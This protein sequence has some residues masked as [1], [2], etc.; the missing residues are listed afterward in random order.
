MIAVALIAAHTLV[1]DLSVDQFTLV[2]AALAVLPWLVHWLLEAAGTT[3]DQRL[4]SVRE[5]VEQQ[6]SR[7]EEQNRSAAAQQQLIDELTDSI[8][9]NYGA[10]QEQQI[11][12]ASQQRML[13]A[14]VRTSEAYQ[15]RLVEQ[16][17]EA[18]ALQATVCKLTDDAKSQRL[19]LAEQR[20]VVAG[21][22]RE[23][24]QLRSQ[25]DQHAKTTERQERLLADQRRELTETT[26]ALKRDHERLDEQYLAVNELQ[27]TAGDLKSWITQHA[28]SVE[29][30][31]IA[32][33]DH[34][35]GLAGVQ[36]AVSQQHKQQCDHQRAIVSHEQSV[37]DVIAVSQTQTGQIQ[38]L[39]DKAEESERIAVEAGSAIDIQRNRSEEQ[40][41]LLADQR[42]ELTETTEA[43]KRD[44]E[45]L[46]EQYLAV[47]ELQRT[48]GD[49]KSWT[50]QHTKSVE[51]NSLAIADHESGLAEVQAAVSQQHEQQCDHGRAIVSHEQS[52]SDVVALSQTQTGRIQ[53]L[54]DKA[55]E[56]ERIA[57][58]A[59]SEIDVQRNR[60]E[61]QERLMV[62]HQLTV[63]EVKASAERHHVQQKEETAAQQSQMYEQTLEGV[64]G[65][66]QQIEELSSG[67]AK[68]QA[69][70]HDLVIFGMSPSRF[71][72]LRRIHEAQATG[73]QYPFRRN[74]TF[75]EE[76]KYL[77]DYGFIDLNGIRELKTDDD[78]AVQVRLTTLGRSF[79][80]L[81]NQLEAENDS[82]FET[83][84]HAALDAP[85]RLEPG[86]AS[87]S[88]AM[89]V[90]DA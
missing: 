87:S 63:S 35:S 7:L 78:L 64:E 79:V 36:A 11:A 41:R 2:V 54:E 47:N 83:V 21:H 8:R 46:D 24:Q 85:D 6:N 58:E 73:G 81:R 69:I 57:V 51:A 17:R 34:E 32:I 39:E 29:A 88:F 38:S 27:R 62:Q 33:A 86:R 75:S 25:A 52:V 14:A 40:E 9:R 80:A 66:R 20:D 30:N 28:K 31:S 82:N 68:Q 1:P 61:E 89:E 26:E 60:S 65:N 23:T 19:E 37:S 15:Q 53:S 76:L 44:H 49:L 84:D 50:T 45:R 67:M 4:R 71:G 55:E 13:D 16:Q 12:L 43:L 42:Q 10:A 3:F 59:R 72:H 56:S 18:K 5:Q 70:V 90:E 74:L 22:K 77:R 48:A